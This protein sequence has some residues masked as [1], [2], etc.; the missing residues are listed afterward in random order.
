[1]VA[2]RGALGQVALELCLLLT[3]IKA[4]TGGRRNMQASS[5]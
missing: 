4:W 3:Q 5:R 2:D 1:M